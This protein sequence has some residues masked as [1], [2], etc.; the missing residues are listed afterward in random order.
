MATSRT[1]NQ[2]TSVLSR[3]VRTAPDDPWELVWGQPYIDTERLAAA[4]E[5][6]LLHT[7]DPDFRTRLLIRDVAR[8]LKSFLGPGRFV[9][10]LTASPVGERIGTILKENLGRPGFRY[11]RRRLVASVNLT[12]IKQVLDLLGQGVHDRIE[13][14]IAGSIPTLIRGLTARPTDDIDIV[15]E[16]PA[17]IRQQRTALKKIQNEYGLT[18]GHVQSH[19]LP[20]NWE[21]RRQYLGD[22]GGIRAYL[23][24]PYD[25]FV[26]KLSSR[27]EKHKQDLRVLAKKLEPETAKQRLLSDGK[28]FVDDPDLRPQIEE[29]WRFIYQEPLFP[30]GIEGKA[31]TSNN[32]TK[33][34]KKNKRGRNPP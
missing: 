28:A 4:I 8:A 13:I 22:F 11:I 21:Q 10:W 27:Q 30:E 14:N 12:E 3:V 26:S 31:R 6:N 16:V 34:V 19:Y 1:T 32:M 18:L 15:D 25:I 29:N 9:R 33:D 5:N 23:V 2:R 17:E 20:A 7:P 24:D